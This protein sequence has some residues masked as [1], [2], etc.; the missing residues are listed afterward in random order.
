MNASIDHPLRSISVPTTLSEPEIHARHDE[1]ETY[2]NQYLSD[3]WEWPSVRARLGFLSWRLSDTALR[4]FATGEF[5]R[6]KLACELLLLGFLMDDWF[7]HQKLEDSTNVVLR[8][9]TLRD[10]PECFVPLTTIETMHHSIFTRILAQDPINDPLIRDS[11][12]HEQ[13]IIDQYVEMLFC[14]CDS[15]RGNF[16]S[17]QKYLAYRE[18]DF[19]INICSTILYW[20]ENLFLPREKMQKLAPL[21]RIANYHVMTLNDIFSFDREWTAWQTC[22]ESAVMMNGVSILAAETHIC[23]EAAKAWSFSLVRTW[24]GEFQ[25]MVRELVANGDME[26]EEMRRAVEGIERRMT[27]AEEFYWQTK[28]YL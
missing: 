4:M 1:I 8:L 18:V 10:A 5:E 7:E 3:T 2:V 15:S 22:G 9:S 21:E 13:L 11:S 20:T 26:S 19:G 12:C 16:D 23:V 14:H 6:V 17:F 28:R 25:R 24:E 27:G